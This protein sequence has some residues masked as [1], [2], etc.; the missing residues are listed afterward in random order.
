MATHFSTLMTR[1]SP[2]S[3]RRVEPRVLDE[4]RRYGYTEQAIFAVRLA[5]EEALANAI[6][7]G[8]H[9]DANKRV[10]VEYCIDDQRA[11]I[12]VCDEGEGFTRCV[13]PDP[14]RPENLEKPTGRGIMLME[15]FM[16]EVRWN[17]RGNQVEM[18]K[19]N[20]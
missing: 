14:T 4:L 3:A 9:G 20:E 6:H 17:D 7:H 5:L 18:V 11:V 16:N 13:V 2:A 19:R 12:R 10:R 1:S 15:A 8:N